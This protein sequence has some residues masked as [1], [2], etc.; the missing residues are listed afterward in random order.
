M[1]AQVTVIL[2][3]FGYD[4]L[5]LCIGDGTYA[6]VY[7]CIGHGVLVYICVYMCVC[8]FSMCKLLH[9]GFSFNSGSPFNTLYIC[10]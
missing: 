10:D 3:Y 7:C 5:S 2:E 4:T 9:S 1:N 6:T 8:S